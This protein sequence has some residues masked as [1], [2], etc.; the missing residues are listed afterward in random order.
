MVQPAGETD[1]GPAGDGPG[2]GRSPR[3]MDVR[4]HRKAVRLNHPGRA[5]GACAADQGQ[6]GSCA[7]K[8]LQVG[9]G[10]PAHGLRART[11]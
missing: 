3:K 9:P 2:R 6:G 1:G 7:G 4:I 5:G 11:L 10:R 8:P